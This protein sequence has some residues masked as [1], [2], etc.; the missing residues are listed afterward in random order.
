MKK[1]KIAIVHDDF[2]QKG[3]AEILVFDLI[4]ELSSLNRFE[5]ALFTS[6]ISNNWERKL[7]NLNIKIYKSFLSRF[8]YSDRISKFYF[9]SNLFYLSFESFDFTEFDVVFSSSTRFGHSII[10]KPDTLHISY[11]N[12]PSKMLWEIRKYFVGKRFLYQLIKNLLPN[13]RVFD[14]VTQQR[15]DIVISN[16]NNIARKIKRLYQRE[17]KVLYP[18]VSISNDILVTKK[19]DYYV[20]ISRL[21]PWKRI[22][23]VIESFNHSSKKLLIIGK[24]N[25]SYINYL[26][27]ISSR[28]IEFLGYVSNEDK[29]VKLK[30]SKALIVPQDEDFGLIIPEALILGTPIIYYNQGG[31]S[32]ILSEKYGQPFENQDAKS[33]SAAITLFEKKEFNTSELIEYG[34]NFTV[35]N[36]TNHLIKLIESKM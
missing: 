21:I 27:S 35:S 29:V 9:I 33:L 24:G 30:N 23:Y 28:N 13:K 25:S 17:S 31:A 7:E 18:F 6:I 22:D 14:F 36:F 19:E 1:L 26:K 2:I 10:T 12:S 3:G 32:E 11:I 16:S 20:L 8:P 4:K 34:K 15:S 5:I